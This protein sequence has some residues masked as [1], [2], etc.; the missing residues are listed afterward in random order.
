MKPKFS[1]TKCSLQALRPPYTELL[2]PQPHTPHLY[3][4]SG[5]R[6]S[7]RLRV[8]EASTALREHRVWGWFRQVSGV[9]WRRDIGLVRSRSEG[10]GSTVLGRGSDPYPAFPQA[11]CPVRHGFPTINYRALRTLGEFITGASRAEHRRTVPPRSRHESA[12]EQRLR[13]LNPSLISR[14]RQKVIQP[15][16]I[17][18]SYNLH[19]ER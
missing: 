14:A 9:G 17:T 15:H 1:L 5:P 16:A 7:E 12:F 3:L 19:P 13:K 10:C 6:L 8:A 18:N 11:R 4:N 2:I